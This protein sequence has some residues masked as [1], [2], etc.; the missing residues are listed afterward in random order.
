M[1][2]LSMWLALLWP[3]ASQAAPLEVFVSVLPQETFVARV[4]GEHVKVSA[5]TRPGQNHETFEPTPQQVA[6]IA[7]ADLFIGIGMPF[8]QAWLPRLRA[9]NPRMRILDAREDIDLLPLDHHDHDEDLGHASQVPTADEAGDPH[10]WT[11]PLLAARMSASIR[12]TLTELDPAHAEDYARNQARFAAELEALDQEIRLQLKDLPS[13]KFLVFHPAWGYFAQAY[14][15]TQVPIEQGGKEPGA[16][17]LVTL[18]EQAKRDQIRVV[19]IQPQSDPRFADQI[20]RAIGGR[21]IAIDPLAPDY[22]AN[23]RAVARQI[24]AAGTPNP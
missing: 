9:A 4:G 12:D 17:T 10:L 22:V 16:R 13:R 23:L 18:I 24:A 8:E 6:D 19:F 1:R 14:D 11:S 15:L 21:V 7:R 20:A 5:L 3:L 2:F